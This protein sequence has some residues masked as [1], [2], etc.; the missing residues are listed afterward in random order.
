M[1]TRSV[2]GGAD[3]IDRIEMRRP[4]VVFR[5]EGKAE[6]LISGLRVVQAAILRQAAEVPFAD[7][8]SRIPY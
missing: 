1:G 2:R 4:G 7:A 5:A 6:S 8:R 3:E